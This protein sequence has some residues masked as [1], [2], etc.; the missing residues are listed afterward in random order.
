MNL[1]DNLRLSLFSQTVKIDKAEAYLKFM[2]SSEVADKSYL[3]IIEKVE[4]QIAEWST[5]VDIISERLKSDKTPEFHEMQDFIINRLTSFGCA[6]HQGYV[7]HGFELDSEMAS[8]LFLE[9]SE[10][11]FEFNETTK[12]DYVILIDRAVDNDLCEDVQKK[13]TNGE[14]NYTESSVMKKILQK[15]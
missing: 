11:G 2:T 3:A 4:L 5:K 9:P 12:P 15:Y 10:N 14:N 1:N 7:M 6:K 13:A 8:Y